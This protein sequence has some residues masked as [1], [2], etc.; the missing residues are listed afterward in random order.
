MP[1]L[2]KGTSC[3]CW[4]MDDRTRLTETAAMLRLHRSL[5]ATVLRITAPR[6]SYSSVGV[7]ERTRNK[8]ALQWPTVAAVNSDQRPGCPVRAPGRNVLLQPP[9]VLVANASRADCRPALAPPPMQRIS[10]RSPTTCRQYSQCKVP[11]QVSR[12]QL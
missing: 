2:I 4:T 8:L 1:P 12:D 3:H 11:R 10:S 7:G 6:L 5:A 9:L